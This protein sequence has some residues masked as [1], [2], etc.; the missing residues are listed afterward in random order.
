[1]LDP[2][3]NDNPLSIHWAGRDAILNN[4][5]GWYYDYAP[6]EG[7]D[8]VFPYWNVTVTAGQTQTFMFVLNQ[9]GMSIANTV[10][11]AEKLDENPLKLYAGNEYIN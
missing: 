3:S 1:M 6:T 4:V 8:F 5:T 10:Q 7:D 9:G 2:M 11:T